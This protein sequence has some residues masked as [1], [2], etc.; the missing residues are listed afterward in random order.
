M[1]VRHMDTDV[2]KYQVGGII[3]LIHKFICHMIQPFVVNTVADS[4]N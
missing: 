3:N 2:Q 1:C 4:K